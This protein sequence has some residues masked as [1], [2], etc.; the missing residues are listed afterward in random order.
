M[1]ENRPDMAQT[2][3]DRDQPKPEGGK[4]KGISTPDGQHPFQDV[5]NQDGYGSTLAADA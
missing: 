4:A 2:G 1:E 5:E 3:G